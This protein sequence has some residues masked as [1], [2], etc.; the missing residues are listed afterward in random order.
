MALDPPQALEGTIGGIMLA[1]EVDRVRE[2]RAHLARH[3]LVRRVA[4][5]GDRLHV[6]VAGDDALA[7]GAGARAAK[8]IEDTLREAGA[9][10]RGVRVVAPSLED[11]FIDRIPAG[12]AA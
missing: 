12:E 8:L 2:A 5:F 6:T 3:P 9:G 1:V 4:L 10:V 11:V 7:G